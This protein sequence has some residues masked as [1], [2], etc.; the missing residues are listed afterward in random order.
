MTHIKDTMT[1]V[2]EKLPN[3]G[4]KKL[5]AFIIGKNAMMDLLK[6]LICK[7]GTICE[8]KQSKEQ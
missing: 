5:R 2:V 3:C 1:K 8:V 6:S 7:A 4:T